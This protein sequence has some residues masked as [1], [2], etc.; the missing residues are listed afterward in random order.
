VLTATCPSCLA[1]VAVRRERVVV[2]WD[3]GAP[4]CE[5][6][7]TCPGCHVTVALRTDRSLL[8]G[9]RRGPA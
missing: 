1:A 6:L 8:S 2:W 5:V 3:E 7:F 4:G 9:L